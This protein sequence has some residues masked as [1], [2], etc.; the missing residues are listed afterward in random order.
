MIVEASAPGKMILFGEHS[1]V[2]GQPAIVLAIDR[3]ARVQADKRSDEKIY[4]DADDLGFS[5]YFENDVYYAVRGKSWRGRNLAALNITTKKTM[6]Y[7]GVK[8]GVNLKVRSMIPIAVGLGSSAAICVATTAAVSTLFEA[9]LSND[10]I[11]KLSF[12]GEKIIH[13]TP[14]GVDN[15]VSTFGGVM[16]Y[17]KDAGFERF[18]LERGMHFIIGNT[19]NKRSTRMMV[20]KVAQLKERN[21]SLMDNIL[22]NMG[23]IAQTGLEALMARDLV[24]LG[25]LM[26][27]NHGLL[28]GIGVST[29]KLESLIHTARKNGALGAKLT[30]AGGG[31]CMIALA[32]DNNI[33]DI[34]RAIRRKKSDSM[35][36]NLTDHGV[37]S[38][39]VEE[40]ADS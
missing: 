16:R 31:G 9:D 7:L 25:D 40:G 33:S 24:T 34:E 29:L 14:S 39:W 21:S 27:L 11:S 26:N 35:R 1:V 2:Y 6:E 30:G 20:E 36:V 8:S 38:K 17:A 37:E 12:E 5:G 23:N 13:G 19:R 4:I 3:R 22:S 18:N 32:L 15:N 10:Q 28:S